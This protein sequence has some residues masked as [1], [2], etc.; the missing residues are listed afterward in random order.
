MAQSP[1]ITPYDNPGA[2]LTAPDFFDVVDQVLL[3][4]G[5]QP[6]DPDG[7]QRRIIDVRESDRVL[8]I[9]AGPGSGKTEM[10][11]LRVLFDL[12]VRGTDPSRLIVTTFTRRAAKEL[13]IRSVERAEAIQ[14]AC[15]ARQIPVRD[16]QVHNLR[17]GTI[18]SLCEQILVEHDAEYR[19][20]GRTMID[21]AEAYARMS[22]K[23]WDLG[24]RGGSGAVDRLMGADALKALFTPPWEDNDRMLGGMRIVDLLTSM[25]SQHVETWVPRCE[26][27]GALNGVEI[28]HGPTGLTDD[29]AK[30]TTRWEAALEEA[31]VVD[32]ATMQRLFRSRQHLFLGRYDHIFVDEFQDS[33]PIQFAI[34]T[35]WLEESGTRLTVVA[36][37]DQ[38]LYR[39]R[40]SDIECLIG[41][42]PHCEGASIPFRQ[43]ALEINYRSTKR[44][45]DFA[46]AFRSSSILATA[47]LGKTIVPA[48]AAP[49]GA[50]VRL[51]SGR[52][53]D[54]C[55][56]VAEDLAL[57]DVGTAGAKETAAILMFS[58][59]ESDS[60]QRGPSPAL[61]LRRTL[62]A[63]GLRVFNLSSKTAAEKGSPVVV[64]LGLLSYFIDPISMA[65]PVGKQRLGMVWASHSDTNYSCQA[66]S[67]PPGWRMNEYH[68]TCQ[69]WFIKHDGGQI[70]SPAAERRRLTDRLD[71]IRNNL[72]GAKGQ[73]RLTMA[74]LIYRLLADPF[75]RQSGF[76][77]D[78]F[79]QALF[80]QLFEANV[81]PTRL[82]MKSLD[83]PL[84]PTLTNGKVEWPDAFWQVLHAFGGYLQN[85][86]VEDIEVESF[87]QDA[88]LMMT[89]HRAKGLEFDHVIA[90]GLGREPD[91]GPALRTRC[92]SGD[93]IPFDVTDTSVETSDPAT[94]QL[95]VADRDREAY[96][97]LS[98]AK[99]TLTILHDADDPPPML[100]ANPTIAALIGAKVAALHPAVPA[101]ELRNW[102]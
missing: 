102:P 58:T 11:I 27:S 13:I 64:L 69:K 43:E 3:E 15:S 1:L 56:A 34:H 52:W 95:A 62:E 50:P 37:D 93:A 12:L 51:L 46:Q 47:G 4:A 19:D 76:T 53:D 90:A 21:Q 79:R 78:M 84:E 60:A 54:V 30:V 39:F 89:H 100:L 77:P 23:L 7:P 97:A 20:A 81:A 61:S 24:R 75:F 14:A 101:V 17:I 70:G 42:K 35:A 55:E 29:L 22:R 98:R 91:H 82:T 40:G 83:S 71:I 49:D 74:G 25:I 6:L 28:V 66:I 65:I 2:T 45:V 68:I 85:V 41:L 38:S 94:V 18:H 31:S 59:R 48:S 16:P 63:K 92:F 80:T 36:D 67:H 99:S 8:Q 10:L 32:F 88:I 72:L 96:V 26:A 73:A 9:L 44:I 33:N 5:R 86:S 87:E 57:L